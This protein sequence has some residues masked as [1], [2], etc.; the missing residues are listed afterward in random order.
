MWR[1]RFIVAERSLLGV[2]VVYALLIYTNE[3]PQN[4]IAPDVNEA[5]LDEHRALQRDTAA[6]GDLLS[7]ARL[8]AKSDAK[9]VRFDSQNHTIT[10]GPY[11][12]TK[13]WLV[14]LYMIE[15]GS[16]SQAIDHAKRLCTDPLWCIEV[17]PVGWQRHGG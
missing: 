12:E 4:P 15:C 9:T 16:Q 5:A 2:L 17:R 8:D 3:S 11:M 1:A 10:D 13:E 6:T 14:G 7:V